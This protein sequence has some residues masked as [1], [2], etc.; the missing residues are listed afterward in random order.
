M[1]SRDN[2]RFDIR[3]KFDGNCLVATPEK[4]NILVN[5]MLYTIAESYQKFTKKFNELEN[6]FDLSFLLNNPV[7]KRGF[8]DNRKIDLNFFSQNIPE[9]PAAVLARVKISDIA[10][11]GVLKSLDEI[12][13]EANIPFSLA[14]YMRLGEALRTFNRG[15][16]GLR[17]ARIHSDSMHDFLVRFKKGS[18]PV[19]NILT[20]HRQMSVITAQLTTVKT[21]HRLIGIPVIE[22]DNLKRI[23]SIW[24]YNALPNKFREFCFKFTNNL[25]GLNSRLAHFV[26]D[27]HP[28]CTFCLKSG[29]VPIPVESFTHLFFECE[30][31][32]F[33]LN[34]LST[35]F[36]AELN[37]QNENEKKRF[38]FCGVNPTTN[39]NDNSFILISVLCILFLI[40]ETKLKKNIPSMGKLCNDFFYLMYKVLKSNTNIQYDKN[41]INL[42]ISRNWD[43]LRDRHG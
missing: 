9:I 10:V 18:R 5:P 41:S 32:T 13:N 42:A 40:W 36:F 27:H 7:L 11:G 15:R 30:K 4:L 24:N 1:S 8:G 25:L 3:K 29:K 33:I 20:K 35:Q 37:F 34:A 26:Q 19:R 12:N 38:W 14:T 6:N 2:W 16:L 21:F 43:Q 31:T 17:G 39:K 23:L 28:G 22:D